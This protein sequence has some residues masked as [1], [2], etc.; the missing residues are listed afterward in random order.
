MSFMVQNEPSHVFHGAEEAFDDVTHF[1][2]RHVM[3]DELSGVAL[4]GDNRQRPAIGDELAD[5]PRAIGLVGDDGQRRSA[6][7]Q[8]VR[9]DLAVMNLAA[10]NDKAP[11]TTV[12]I[13]YG[14]NLAC[15]AT[16]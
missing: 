16:A 7:I 14:V 15:A 1:I 5:G 10:G 8:K 4:R 3:G 13:N 12:F 2:E 11:G 9:H 6:T